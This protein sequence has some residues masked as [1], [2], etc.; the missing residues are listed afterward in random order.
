[1]IQGILFK[2]MAVKNA[3]INMLCAHNWFLTF[4]PIEEQLRGSRYSKT[5][6]FAS[7][8]RVFL[9]VQLH[10]VCHP[11]L[12]TYMYIFRDV[13]SRTQNATVPAWCPTHLSA[14]TILKE[15]TFLEKG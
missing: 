5:H 6:L 12:H 9:A 11:F 1:M 7:Y 3:I 8:L 4:K 13:W 2:S 10:T 14:E 15:I